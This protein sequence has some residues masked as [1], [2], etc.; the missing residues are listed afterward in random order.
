VEKFLRTG[1]T[2]SFA[3]Q[4]GP[5][6]AAVAA[7][8]VAYV[9]REGLGRLLGPG[10]PPFI[11]FY[12]TIMIVALLAGMRPGILATILASA[13]TELLIYRAHGTS[14]VSNAVIGFSLILFFAMGLGMSIVAELYRQARRKAADYDR[15]LQQGENDSRLSAVFHSSLLG[16]SIIG[17]TDRRCRDVNTAFLTMFGYTRDEVLGRPAVQLGLLAGSADIQGAMNVL[18]KGG[19]LRQYET[20]CR[21]K[22][23]A[24]WTA[25]ISAEVIEL[26]GEKCIWA[27]F[28][29]V[30]E[31]KRNEER[32]RQT[33]DNMLEGCQIIGAD[34]RYIYINDAAE[35][36]NRRPREELIG[37]NYVEMWPGVEATEVYAALRRC[38]DDGT[39]QAMEN[40]FFFPDGSMGCFDLR[41]SR[42]PEGIVIL[43]VDITERKN[44]ENAVRDSQLLLR[45][46]I[47][48]VP[49]F[50]FAKDRNSRH[51]FVNKACAVANGRTVEQ[52]IGLDDLALES[53]KAQAELFMQNDRRVIDEG[54]VIDDEE[55]LT[56]QGGDTRVL[57]TIKI[58][59]TPPGT[60]QK[61]LMGV[62]VDITE[63]KR[64][65]EEVRTLNAELE[66]R[67]EKRTAELNAANKEL[68][69]FAY[70]VSHDLR[71]PL[72]ALSGFSQAL[73]EDFGPQLSGGAVTYL[74][75]ITISSRRM[76]DLIEGILRLSRSARGELQ[77]ESFSLS[78]IAERIFEDLQKADPGRKVAW[79][80][81]PGLTARGD[82][83]LVEV[84]LANLLEN[85]W[86]YTARTAEPTIRFSAVHGNG[87]QAFR[88]AD[89]GA[90]FDMGHAA[91]LFQPFQ[92]LHRQ[93]EFPGIGIGLATVQR[94]ITR[95]GG[96]I[97]ATGTP[98][99]GAAFTFNL[100]EQP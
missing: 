23:G 21:T 70:A 50:I 32:F 6:A 16:M 12:P 59:F 49:H 61:A 24:P 48:L 56:V 55:L 67:V 64:A 74:D 7:V 87:E 97:T 46:V 92:R 89:N 40:E 26:S 65:E 33:L 77:M 8:A 34:W 96:T 41:T 17:M 75:Q 30:T 66:K 3:R 1:F 62:A 22:T 76:S 100:G 52:M 27:T 47:D 18:Q 43:S 93:D 90:G 10:L 36:H 86:K 79:S 37:K 69:A 54:V 88:V 29:D 5:F 53:D 73:R 81:E 14:A 2:S 57:H 38:M 60:V 25:L 94:I 39:P 95:H 91:R 63:L 9:T 45:Q 98:G 51:L 15:R 78:S 72:R 28:Q 82:P 19:R 68:E 99:K 83:R 44:S 84:A 4:L 35:R 85:S 20:R 13:A 58:P 71:A 42:V 11:L 31:R 80:V